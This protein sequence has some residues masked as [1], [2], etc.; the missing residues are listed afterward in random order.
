MGDSE[1]HAVN[2][3]LSAAYDLSPTGLEQEAFSRMVNE[4][5]IAGESDREV[6]LTLAG[7]I[8]DGLKKG[9]WPR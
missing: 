9:N 5:R 8:Y 1:R 2:Q 7:C 4:M 3:L 6:A